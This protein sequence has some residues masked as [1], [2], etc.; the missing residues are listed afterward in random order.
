MKKNELKPGI[1]ES[2]I[3]IILFPYFSKRSLPGDI[4]EDVQ[5]WLIR[6]SEREDVAKALEKIWDSFT[7]YE[8][9]YPFGKYLSLESVRA[10]LAEE[11]RKQKE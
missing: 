8:D 11:R 10:T 3:E 6:N 2:F 4:V 5:R 7:K 1:P 9:V